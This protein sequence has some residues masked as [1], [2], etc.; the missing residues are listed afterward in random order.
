MIL[1]LYDKSNM[2]AGTEIILFMNFP[3]RFQVFS[4]L[5]VLDPTLRS[6]M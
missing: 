3:L 4:V 2:S 1:L 6:S 5:K